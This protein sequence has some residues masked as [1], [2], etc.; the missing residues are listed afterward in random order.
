MSLMDRLETKAVFTNSWTSAMSA[1][2]EQLNA[3]FKKVC[4]GNGFVWGWKNKMCPHL[5]TGYGILPHLY[6]QNCGWSVYM[7]VRQ[8]LPVKVG[9]PWPIAVA[10]VPLTIILEKKEMGSSNIQF[11]EQ[12]V[13]CGTTFQSNQIK[14]NQIN[15]SVNQS[16]GLS[17]DI[18]QLG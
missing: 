8:P 11:I 9:G 7:S 3:G 16:M 10:K 18:K 6:P 4:E 1:S 14:S 15:Q 5:P 17:W 13:G 2:G 12:H